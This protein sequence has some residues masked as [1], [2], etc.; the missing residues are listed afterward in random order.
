M[1]LKEIFEKNGYDNK[2][3][4]RCLQTFL[5]KIYSKKVPQH[6]VP[7]TDLYIFFPYL[8]KL[9]LSAR[10]TLEKTICDI[11]PC[12]KLK[13]V[14][15][16]KNRLSSKFIS[17]DKISKEM[18]SLLC[19]KFQCSSCNATYYGKTK[20]HFKVR[21]SKHMGVSAH[22]GKNIKATKNSAV[23]DHMVV[24]NNTVTFEDFS[25]LTNRTNDFGIKLQE[26]LL[27]HRDGPQLNKTSESAP[28]M[29]F[30]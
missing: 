26:S 3:F 24:F 6:T 25:V 22:T 7:K 1:Q 13:V 9:S 18:R 16:I 19:Y 8:G 21:V 4:D 27:I 28:L 15:R 12:V 30:S 2:F 14:F 11:L 29:L 20:R 23:R 10:S 5:N 17:K